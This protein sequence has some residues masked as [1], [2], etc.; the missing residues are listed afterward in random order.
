MYGKNFVAHK[1]ITICHKFE[2]VTKMDI[3]RNAAH[4]I[5]ENN[6]ILFLNYNSLHPNP[7]MPHRSYSICFA[8]TPFQNISNILSAIVILLD[9]NDFRMFVINFSFRFI[10]NIDIGKIVTSNCDSV[11]GTENVFLSDI[12]PEAQD[13]TRILF[14]WIACDGSN[15]LNNRLIK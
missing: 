11:T 5:V 3:L 2:N 4:S 8:Q 14:I 13:N 15:F 12:A 1:I 10:V 6:V 7:A 9:F